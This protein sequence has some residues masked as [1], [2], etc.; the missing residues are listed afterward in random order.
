MF[1][2]DGNLMIVGGKSRAKKEV[3]LHQ[4]DPPA[5]GFLNVGQWE[6]S[7]YLEEGVPLERFIAAKYGKNIAIMGETYYD[8]I[9]DTATLMIFDSEK[10]E[11]HE[12]QLEKT[13]FM[14]DLSDSILFSDGKK[15]LLLSPNLQSTYDL[16]SFTLEEKEWKK[17]TL[18]VDE[19]VSPP[20][21]RSSP[22]HTIMGKNRLVVFGG[23][24]FGSFRKDI[25]VL[26]LDSFSWMNVKW[27]GPE[28]G[29]R[30]GHEVVS[31]SDSSVLVFGGN[32]PSIG[33][34]DS[35]C[36]INFEEN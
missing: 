12:W 1:N 7:V 29:A 17:E 13:D 20:E 11:W 19:K 15:L 22:A 23:I 9:N 31:L 26:D 30:C 4:I 14:R 28:P 5:E 10:V 16:H 6:S 25:S 35:L 33:A 36:V 34:D 8:E 2:L 24:S 27:D 21:S 32:T 3:N 18:S